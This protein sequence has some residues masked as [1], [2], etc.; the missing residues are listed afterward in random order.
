MQTLVST[1]EL[2]KR[3]DVCLHLS[4]N[5]KKRLWYQ[6]LEMMQKIT[7]GGDTQKQSQSHWSPSENSLLE[8]SFLKVIEDNPILKIK[9]APYRLIMTYS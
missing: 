8:L 1:I 3:V 2:F 6:E 7:K 4:Q 9:P 5:F